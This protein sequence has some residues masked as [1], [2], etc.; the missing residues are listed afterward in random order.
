MKKIEKQDTI[1][2]VGAGGVTSYLIA[3]L[4]KLLQFKFD[5]PQLIIF[6][7]DSLEPRNLERQLFQK[8]QI[9]QNKA[10]ALADYVQS[11]LGYS[12]VSAV[13]EY[14]HQSSDLR[15]DS[16]QLILCAVDNH[17]ARRTCLSMADFVGCPAILAGNE[18]TDAE[19]YIYLP[20]WK[21]SPQDPR[22][23]FP[24]ILTDERDNPLARN[25]CTG[26][27]TQ[28]AP[29]L[30]VANYMAAGY[31][32]HLLWFWTMEFQK[33]DEDMIGYRPVR[34]FNNFSRVT[35]KT[36]REHTGS[37]VPLPSAAD[38]VAVAG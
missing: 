21:D 36:I 33:V 19:A 9:G 13:P 12:K 4:V 10:E 35:T 24:E 38:P 30:C 23:Y 20:E 26:A 34:H 15:S 18:Y 8:N 11:T 7:G 37:V 31:M 27:A 16:V 17:P 29:Q 25:A 2:L 6:D 32:L 5:G 28:A 3:P 1:I 14:L 22:V